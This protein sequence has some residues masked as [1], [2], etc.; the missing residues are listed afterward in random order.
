MGLY[1]QPG[2]IITMYGVVAQQGEI[3][4]MYGIVCSTRGDNN[5]VWDCMFNLV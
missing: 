4:A 2:E 3:I 1:A 5:N